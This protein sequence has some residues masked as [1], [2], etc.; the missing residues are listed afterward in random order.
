VACLPVILQAP[1]RDGRDVLRAR[2]RV[3]AATADVDKSA[4][5]VLRVREERQ[6]CSDICLPR[7]V[8]GQL[9][10][11]VSLQSA[12]PI[13]VQQA[14]RGGFRTEVELA[15]DQPERELPVEAPPPR[16]ADGP[17]LVGQPVVVFPVPRRVPEHV[18]RALR[19]QARPGGEWGVVKAFGAQIQPVL[20]TA[21][22]TGESCPE[23]S[24]R[25]LQRRLRRQAA[26]VLRALPLRQQPSEAPRLPAQ[27]EPVRQSV[28]AARELPAA[29]LRFEDLP[30]S[31]P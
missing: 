31:V 11:P 12:G 18:R 21:L 29:P 8:S 25:P 14:A 2:R 4:R 10:A 24:Q 7:A 17:L 20:P 28:P 16:W 3:L 15:A 1:R 9:A 13:S 6:V 27:P 19:E 5:R 30:G 22:R 23:S 26:W